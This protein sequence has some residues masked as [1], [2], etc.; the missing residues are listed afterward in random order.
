MAYTIEITF[1]FNFLQIPIDHNKLNFIEGKTFV[2]L[3]KLKEVWLGNNKCIDQDFT[4]SFDLL[5][6]VVNEQCGFCE[7]STAIETHICGITDRVRTI[8]SKG[9]LKPI[10]DGQKSHND[11]IRSVLERYADI[12]VFEEKNE[13]LQKKN[14]VLQ[15]KNEVLQA[16]ITR[17]AVEFG[18][19]QAKQTATE[20]MKAAADDQIAT[21]K[22]LKDEICTEKIKGLNEIIEHKLQEQADLQA[23]LQV[24][25]AK[26]ADQN[27]KI[28]N[29]EEKIK[30]IGSNF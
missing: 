7:T 24:K 28:Y 23:E 8:S 1:A 12:K 16:E 9:F 15:T 30:L 21:I 14:G 2:G 10:L 3:T 29:L 20:A 18:K 19:L 27:V 13:A 11:A 5:P 22:L 25:T 4:S 26:I 17:N 6:D